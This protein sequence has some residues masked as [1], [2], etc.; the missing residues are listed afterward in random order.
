MDC[1]PKKVAVVETWPLVQVRLYIFSCCQFCVKIHIP[2][3]A[4]LHNRR[5]MS[6]ARRTRH[7]GFHAWRKMSRSVRLAHKAPAPF[8]LVRR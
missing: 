8:G 6:Q 2:L 1:P 7:F 4:S 5:F 3:L